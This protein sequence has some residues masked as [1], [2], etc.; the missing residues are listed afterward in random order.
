M[1]DESGA[2]GGLDLCGT[3]AFRAETR[4]G[5]PVRALDT[6]DETAKV[7]VDTYGTAKAKRRI[8]I[9]GCAEL[10]IAPCT[11]PRKT[12]CALAWVALIPVT[13]ATAV[14]TPV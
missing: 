13:T 4:A 7:V 9:A 2:V 10:A 14:R 6:D 12:N 1:L 11:S 8:I 3:V 5:P